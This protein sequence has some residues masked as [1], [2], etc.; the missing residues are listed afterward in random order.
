MPD[1]QNTITLD[2]PLFIR[3]MGLAR[4]NIKDDAKL[5]DVAKAIVKLSV[6]GR[7]L[8]M[9]DYEKIMR[10]SGVVAGGRPGPQTDTEVNNIRRRAGL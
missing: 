2:V 3:L 1:L 10:A 6:G 7:A 8:T 9:N 5:N 4:E